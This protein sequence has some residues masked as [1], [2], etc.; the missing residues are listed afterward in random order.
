MKTKKIVSF[1]IFL[2]HSLTSVH[3]QTDADALRYSSGS[4]TGTA[5]YSAMAG[6]FGAL[7]GDFTTLSYN[8]AGIAIYRSSEFTFTP[9]VY[10]G[11]T[12]STFSGQTYKDDKS[13]FNIGN[14]GLIYTKILSD[15]YDSPG[16][17][18]W[19]FGFGYNRLNDF[20]NRTFYQGNNPFNSMLDHFAENATGTDPDFL[21]PFFEDLA[22]NAYMINP[23]ANNNYTGV[24]PDGKEIQRRSSETKGSMGE[25]VF[26]FGSNYSNKL[27]AGLTFGFKN[28]RYVETS[29]YEEFDPDTAIPY[30]NRFNFIQD[31]T[32][33]GFGFDM[34]FGLIFRP[35]DL[36]RIG[37][38]IETPTWYGMHDNYINSMTGYLDTGNVQNYPALSPD[39]F[40]DY[41]L[42]TPFKARGSLAFIFGK[43]G[44]LSGD[45]EYSNYG[46]AEF[47]A[48]GAIFSD[49]NYLI[50]RKYKGVHTVRVGTE[51]LFESISLRGGASY[52]SSPMNDVY[53]SEG[54]D[55]SKMSYSGGIGF[56]EKNLFADLSYVYTSSDEYF[57]P[58]SLQNEEVP[59]V[60]SKIINSNFLLTFGVKF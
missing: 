22:Y 53:I 33:T 6:A 34:K 41:D 3:A 30:F 58:Y 17:K 29:V 27:Y 49:V 19:N 9:S 10:F 47:Y 23:D 31:I 44:L 42:T 54:S 24:I 2:I 52:T 39:G 56:R 59:G 48:G 12:K 13:N 7:G 4:L 57:Q 26:T 55:F 25:T 45:Y 50:Q 21:D 38:A 15:D 46:D 20:H 1:S 32:T 18:N 28:I 11:N 51:W 43:N 14:V 16:F 60:K 5:R 37:G 35:T 40:Y 36:V 8:P